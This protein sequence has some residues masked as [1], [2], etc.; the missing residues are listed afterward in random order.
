MRIGFRSCQTT[1]V[2]V[3]LAVLAGAPVACAQMRGN[4][5]AVDTNHDGHVSLQEFDTYVTNRLMAA[6]GV[7]AER[8]K[9]LSQQEQMA[10]LQQRFAQLDRAHK[11]YLDR[12]DWPGS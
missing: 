1:T 7:R 6:H 11:G 8:F 4:F 10:R 5:D 3:A 12:N 9:Q 2:L